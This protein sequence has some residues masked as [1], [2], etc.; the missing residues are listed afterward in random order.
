M[1][2]LVALGIL[3][4]VPASV[5]LAQ[6][7]APPGAEGPTGEGV[8]ARRGAD[9]LLGSALGAIRVVTPEGETL[10]D[11]SDVVLSREGRVIAFVVGVGGLLGVAEKPVAILWE[12]LRV[13]SREA[14]LELVCD[15]G[16]AALDAAPA[17]RERDD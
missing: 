16:R 11:V 15:L 8:I 2:A 3:L 14:E 12:H 1:R 13:R 17:Y 7:T 10:G 5:P 9:T 4:A 6:P